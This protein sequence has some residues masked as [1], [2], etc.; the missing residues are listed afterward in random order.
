MPPVGRT[1][2]GPGGV[3]ADGDRRV[4][5]EEDRAGVGQPLG[6]PVGVGGRDVQVLGGDQVRQ[7]DRLVLVADQDQGAEA[8]EAVAGQVAPAEPGELLGQGVGDAVDQVGLPG[9]QD[10]GARASARPG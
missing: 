10:A 4:V 2:D 9:D 7:L 3:V 1:C 5:A 6:E 8:F